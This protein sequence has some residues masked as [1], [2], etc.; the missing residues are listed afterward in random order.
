MARV[1]T[2]LNQKGGVG[3]TTTALNLGAALALRGRRVLLIDLDPQANLTIGLGERARDLS[4][5]VYEL[6]TDPKVDAFKFILHTKWER[7]DLIRS[8]IDLSGVEIEMIPMI[9]RETKLSRALAP[10]LPNYDY[11]L[12]DCLPSLSMLTVNAMVAASEV[13][14]PLQAHPFAMEGLGKLFEVVKMIN[15]GINKNLN[16]TGVLVT[17]YDG[18]TNVSKVV[19]EQLRSDP[20]LNQHLFSTTVK[21]NIKVAESQKDGVPVM[22]YDPT[23][24]AARAY[25]A[26]CAEVLEMESGAT[27][28]ACADRIIERDA[29]EGK[30]DRTFTSDVLSQ[31]EKLT[32]KSGVLPG[33]TH[34]AVLPP[35][36]GAHSSPVS[37][38]LGIIEPGNAPNNAASETLH[39]YS[40]E[41]TDS[42]EPSKNDLPPNSPVA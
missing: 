15:D 8:H 42:V 23:C 3:K 38:L 35:E 4:E 7:L 33:D 9:G 17:M 27:A 24:H 40:G 12:I 20:R 25:M 2:I 1:I 30:A 31:P 14:V 36:P 18:R 22:Q 28:S 19:L 5:S 39:P 34:G 6:L 11:I 21:Q 32:R 37:A 13:F 41:P 10:V 26:L 29:A 16:V